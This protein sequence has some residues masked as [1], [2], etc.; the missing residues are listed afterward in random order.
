MSKFAIDVSDLLDIKGSKKEVYLEEE[1]A[2][3]KRGEE[4]FLF[5]KP[6]ELNI[7]FESVLSGILAKGSAR[8]EIM[9]ICG[10][11][12][13]EVY[14]SLDLEVEE[15]FAKSKK[16]AE[17]LMGKDEAGEVYF[18]AGTTIDLEPAIRQAI[19]LSL[20]IQPLCSE[21]C[22]GLC[23]KCGQ[24]RNRTKCNCKI[25]EINVRMEKLRKLLENKEPGN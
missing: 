12:L 2:P 18:I 23:P 15:V 7:I 20:P 16:Q 21:V 3:I 6:V 24:N 17:V 11:C 14:L 4:E 9:A 10:R 13:N 1:I 5:S 8:T 25:E 22:K 19:L